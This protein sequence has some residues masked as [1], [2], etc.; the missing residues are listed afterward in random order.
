MSGSSIGRSS[1][2]REDLRFVT[3]AGTFTSDLGFD[4]MLYATFVRSIEAHGTIVGVDTN[5]A[6][7]LDGV[8]A[9]FTGPQLGSLVIAPPPPIQEAAMARPVLATDRVRFAGEPV[10]FVLASSPA[11]AVDAAVGVVVDVEPLPVVTDPADA[12]TGEN[13]LFPEAGTNIAIERSVGS[14]EAESDAPVRVRVQVISPRVDP[15]TMEPFAAVAVPEA[16]GTTTLWCGS[17][18]PLRARGGIAATLGLNPS[19]VTVRVGDVGGAFGQRGGFRQ[20]YVAIVA[21]ARRLGRPVKWVAT[22]REQFLTG[23]HG[24]D[25]LHDVLMEAGEDGVIRRAE[26]RIL[27]NLGAYPHRG[28]FIPLEAQKS[29]SGAY[30]IPEVAVSTVGVVTNTAPT[31]PYRGAGRPEAGLVIEQALDAVAAA[32]GI[33]PM[34]IRRRNFVRPGA[35]PLTTTTGMIHDGG[36]YA[37]LA[38]RA[39][40]LLEPRAQLHRSRSGPGTK[41]GVGYASFVETTAGS[42][43]TGEYARVEIT[44]DGVHVFTGSISTGQGH[45]TVWPQIVS[46][47][48]GVPESKVY[49]IAGDTRRIPAGTGTFGSRSAP[50]GAVAISRAAQDVRDQ[51]LRLAAELLEADP[52]DLFLAS[53]RIGVKGVPGATLALEEVAATA[54]L[55]GD[56]LVAEDLFVPDDQTL[57]SGC[58]GALVSLDI[59]TGSFELLDLVAVDDCGVQINP[60]IVAGQIHGGI[61][62]G[63]GQA[64][65][66]RIV[67]DEAGQVQT[68]TLMDYSIPDARSVP[69]FTTDHRVTP[70]PANH[71]GVKGVGEAGTIGAPPAIVAAVRAAVPEV[72]SFDLELPLLPERVWRAVSRRSGA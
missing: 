49:V 44:T 57:S 41:I 46:E 24:R 66:E 55:R 31:G 35:M 27:G 47:I 16:D 30:A 45:E 28:F 4:G 21:A 59:E 50:L 9:V 17:G 56:V 58:Y 36:D 61:A 14:M 8:A 53:G 2:R 63:L 60:M 65:F 29:A 33:D 72:A 26:F 48:L 7:S 52:G 13:L 71:L 32:V 12:L 25:V 42:H 62:Q 3:G 64:M 39:R 20:E 67:Y 34:E 6:E 11:R 40:E 18:G 5:E 68:T 38:R 1:R 37:A 15:V 22:R 69:S 54:E 70:S 51:V 10:A 23:E 43:E 19:D